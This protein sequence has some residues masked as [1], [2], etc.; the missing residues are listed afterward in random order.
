MIVM[1]VSVSP[2]SIARAIVDVERGQARTAGLREAAWKVEHRL[3]QDQPVG[4]HDQYVG[5][6]RAQGVVLGLGLRA[7]P[8]QAERERRAGGDAVRLRQQPHRR[9]AEL[10]AAARRPIGLGQHQRDRPVLR[11]RLR[12]QRR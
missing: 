8:L 4:G 1:P 6:R 3:R 2:A 10:H 5:L 12:D 9:G 7:A 11:R